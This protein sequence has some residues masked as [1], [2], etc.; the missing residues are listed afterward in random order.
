[1]ETGL[2]IALGIT[3]L[4]GFLLIMFNSVSTESVKYKKILEYIRF[5][6]DTPLTENELMY[7]LSLLQL[8][9]YWPEL[10][11]LAKHEI[12]IKIITCED[13]AIKTGNSKIGGFPHLPPN[14]YK[15]NDLL[16]LGQINCAQIKVFDTDN[17]FPDKGLFYF[18]VDPEKL[19]TDLKESIIIRYISELNNLSM[20][21]NSNVAPKIK[22]GLMQFSQSISLP[23]YDT[24]FIQNLLKDY[25]IDGYF[26]LTNREQYN[27]M[28]GYPNT[29]TQNF[30]INNDK[31]LLLQL[32][33]EELDN[34]LFGNMGRLYIFIDKNRLKH[35]Q[36]DE[37]Y[38]YMQSYESKK[39]S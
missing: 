28:L 12:G 8:D 3:L 34:S 37:L 22:P 32:D 39:N 33:S 15:Y 27:K 36:F 11:P 35:L 30:T 9:K 1:M 21:R 17:L 24:D 19:K 2:V 6:E 20:Q 4:V 18:F 14:E 38:V 10:Y 16:F 31:I 7:R 25:E 26:K 23:E 5:D 29:I 13:E